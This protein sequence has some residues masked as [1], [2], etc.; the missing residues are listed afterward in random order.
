MIFQTSPLK[1]IFSKIVSYKFQFFYLI[2]FILVVGCKQK[3]FDEP[4]IS[5]ASYQIEDG[6]ELQV[7]VSEPLIEAPVA[8]DFD[9]KGRMWVVEMKGYMRNLQGVGDEMPN[10]VI[11]IMEDLD[12]DGVADHSKI[13]LDSLILPR[14]IAHVYGG[15]LYA[16]PPMLWFV[17]IKD[18]KPENRILVDSSYA[19]GGNV[20]HQPNGL[21]MHLDNWIYNAKSKFR[22]QRKKGEWL[23]EKT[24]FRGQWGITKDNFG[25]L[26]YNTNSVQ[27]IGDYVLPNTTN[28]NLNYKGSALQNKRLTP[29]QRVFPL[30]ATSVN[31][32]YVKGVLD[33]DS[34]LVNVTSA[35]GP[36]IYTG[37]NFGSEF[38]ENAFV[39]APEANA[40]KR[41][42]LTFELFKVKARQAVP[43]KEFIVSTDEGFRPV[44][45]NN[46]PDGNMYVVDM[47]RGIL[48][49]KVF[50]TS[51]LKNQYAEKKLD[52]IIGMGRIL[53][54][55][56][57]QSVPKE[58]INI[59]ELS[60]SELV[61]LLSHKNGWL[62][63]RAQQLLVFKN[64]P[65]AIS[66]LENVIFDSRNKIAK[67]H[68]LHT[69]N[70]MQALSFNTLER[71]LKLENES[72]VICHALVLVESHAT[73]SRLPLM[74]EI[75]EE[76][77]GKDNPEVDLYIL[78]TLNGWG[79][80]SSE[81]VFPILSKLSE[82]YTDNLA[83]QESAINSLR[84][85]EDGYKLYLDE[86]NIDISENKLDVILGETLINKQDKKK[87][88]NVTKASNTSGYKIFRNFCATCH[89]FNGEG[90]EQLAPPLENSEYVT[91]STKR[92]TLVLLHGLAGP[93]H[94][95]G[96]LYELNGTMPGLANNP[97]FT[98]LDILN[99]IS[100]LQSTFSKD[101]ESIN[102]DQI[103]ALRNVKPKGGGVYSEKELLN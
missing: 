48:Q 78:N 91:G 9:N 89:G 21:M 61:D 58:I 63:D 77:T 47:H 84:G 51:Y 86:E 26:Y 57:K 41:N 31:R 44:N 62:R 67:V 79:Q 60:V 37:D 7:A 98:N 82:K 65:A 5:L 55:I 53:R 99:I 83:Y 27:L 38:I 90:V 102:L 18:D 93:V 14:A 16:E 12:H 68:A 95:N 103:K 22:Y 87:K 45:L 74:L 73:R 50:L 19:D 88:R 92:L 75:I 28:K 6:F 24:A 34:V 33:K 1:A 59:E 30:H 96:K 81:K 64:D 101:S 15:L 69:L 40:V 72:N 20:E 8:M 70:G 46:G 32:G 56:N 3:S 36:L 4:K 54:V 76:L 100:Y 66:L 71:V 25:R 80:I 43:K 11:S 94:V 29:N 97:A 49:D 42:I 17:D 35:C 2:A 23:K 10:G 39:C 52:S 85:I 13:F